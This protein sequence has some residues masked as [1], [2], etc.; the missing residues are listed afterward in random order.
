[1]IFHVWCIGFMGFIQSWVK[2]INGCFAYY[3]G[4]ENITESAKIGKEHLQTVMMSSDFN[5]TNSHI[6]SNILDIKKKKKK[7]KE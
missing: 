1:M 5:C 7:K 2:F 4:R 6:L 3:F